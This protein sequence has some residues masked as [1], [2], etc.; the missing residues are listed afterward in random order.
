MAT[1][2]T[3]HRLVDVLTRLQ[4]RPS[5]QQQLTICPVNSNTMTF[6]G[7]NEKFELIE[8]LLHRMIKLQPEKPEMSELMKNIHFIHF[9]AKKPYKPSETST[10]AKDKPWRRY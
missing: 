6:D 4:N 2:D 9:S 7:E 1:Q 10:R 3:I 8:D 5:A